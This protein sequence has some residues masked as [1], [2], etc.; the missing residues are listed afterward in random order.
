[1]KDFVFTQLKNGYRYNSDTL[2]LYDFISK[3]NLH[4]SVLEVGAG[5][6]IIG[7]LLKNYFEKIE[8]FLLDILK[9][10]YELCKINLKQNNTKAELFCEDFFNFSCEK[11]FDFLL[12]NPP[13]YKTGS[14]ESLNSHKKISKFQ[15]SFCIDSFFKKANSLLKP[16]GV[17][18]LCYQSSALQELMQGITKYKLRLSKI[19]FIHKDKNTKAR[20]ILLEAR[21]SFKGDSLIQSPLFMYEDKNLSLEYKEFLE[22]LRIKSCDL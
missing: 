17:L 13:F 7:I 12:S 8:L 22:S 4:G 21:K 20:L 6:G 14:Q 18:Y 10:N 1:M 15:S 9:E 16:R 2:L 11:K 19:R 3:N 5:C